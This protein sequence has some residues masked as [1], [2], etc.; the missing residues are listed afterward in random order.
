VFRSQK[1]AEITKKV[2]RNVP[3]LIR[4]RNEEA[5][6]GQT[7][8]PWG[9]SFQRMFDMSNDSGLFYTEPGKDLLPLYE[10]KMIH[11]FDHRWGTF[12]NPVPAAK[13]QRRR[14]GDDEEEDDDDS[15]RD[16]TL[17]EKAQADYG[18]KPRY[19]VERRSVT[20]RT[21]DA[22]P[23]LVKAW[24]EENEHD[25]REQLS[26]YGYDAELT[27]I[28]RS[29]IRD[30]KALFAEVTKLLES[31]CPTWLMGWRGITNVTNERTV[32][33]S[34]FP[35]Y[36][37]GNSLT[38]PIFDKKTNGILRSLLY[39]NLNV[40]VLDYIARQKVGGTNLNFFYIMQFPVLPPEKYSPEDIQFIVPRVFELTYTANDM[41]PWAEDIW[42]AAD[43]NLRRLLLEQ[44]KAANPQVKTINASPPIPPFVFNP[45]RRTRLRA[46]L[47]ARYARLYGLTREEL[48]YI[49]DPQSVMGADYPSQT[50]PGLKRKEEA[51]SG[52]YR[53]RRLVL[54][55]WDREEAIQ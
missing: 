16:V 8:N 52:E 42:N 6:A 27:K 10:A 44:A 11:Q 7:G 14:S 35:L 4:E 47:D 39:T 2:Y 30:K 32:I 5:S 26:L 34:S 36:A 40:L 19:W 18:I 33:T 9:I 15:C 31:R 45:E 38:I 3:V 48:C 54:E 22:P 17:V 24:L 41:K 37:A 1:D 13:P 46:E 20:A 49:L 29:K 50:F 28:Y 23:M 51:E 53:T 43:E 12:D 21:T 25:E 55:A